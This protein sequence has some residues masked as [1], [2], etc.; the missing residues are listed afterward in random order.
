MGTFI[1]KTQAYRPG[2]SKAY[3]CVQRALLTFILIILA[4]CHYALVAVLS[5]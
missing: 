4:Y 1:Y 3:P 2:F 5:P